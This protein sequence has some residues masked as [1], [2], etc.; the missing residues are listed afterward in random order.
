MNHQ[1]PDAT[2][3]IAPRNEEDTV[4]ATNDELTL[5]SETFDGTTTTRYINGSEVRP[6]KRAAPPCDPIVGKS[7][8]RRNKPCP[9]GSGRKYKSCCR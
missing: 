6:V 2:D 5:I 7:R 1:N 4:S 8:I 9:C 3:Y